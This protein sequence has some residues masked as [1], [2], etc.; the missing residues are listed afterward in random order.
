M[1]GMSQKYGL[2]VVPKSIGLVVF[3]VNSFG[4]GAVISLSAPIMGCNHP[5]KDNEFTGD[6]AGAKPNSGLYGGSSVVA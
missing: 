3:P 4:L 6:G 1:R 5:S 2:S